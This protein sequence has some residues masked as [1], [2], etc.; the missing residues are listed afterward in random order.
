MMK[1][2]L[3]ATVELSILDTSFRGGIRGI[4]LLSLNPVCEEHA[5]RGH[6]YPEDDPEHVEGKTED[7]G[8]NPVP[9]RNGEAHGKKGNETDDD[10]SHGWLMHGKPSFV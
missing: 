7:K 6:E 2:T 5:E 10:C 9:Q 3:K 8:I 1:M 4:D